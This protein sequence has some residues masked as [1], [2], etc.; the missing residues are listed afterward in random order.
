[1]AELPRIAV[2]HPDLWLRTAQ[3]IGHHPRRACIGDE[4]IDRRGGQQHPLPPRLAGDAR[5]GFVGTDHRACAH[6]LRQRLSGNN[7]RRLRAGQDVS[8][9]PL[10]DGH[11]E[12]LGHQPSEAL[13][14]DR[15]GDVEV[16]DER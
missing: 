6:C 5:G 2:G 11:A 1:M 10:A 9:G 7:Q 13:K 14:A 3:E 8:D 4:V 15:L 12:H 16:D